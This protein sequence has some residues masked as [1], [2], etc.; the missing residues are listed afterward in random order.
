MNMIQHKL[1]QLATG[2]LLHDVGMLR[3]PDE[4]VSKKGKLEPEE[5]QKIK[6]IRPF[7]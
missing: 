7:L 5:L 1:L 4:I 6:A 3:L 2:A